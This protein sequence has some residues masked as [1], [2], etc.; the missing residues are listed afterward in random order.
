MR[1]YQLKGL[2]HLLGRYCAGCNTILA[3]EMGLGK[4][5]QTI[6][7]LAWLHSVAKVS[8]PHLVIVPLSTLANWCAEFKRFAPQL[9]VLACTRPTSRSGSASGPRFCPTFGTSM[10]L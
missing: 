1:S 9:R 8:G 3:D 4:T 10:S 2:N 6:S 5:L 7:V